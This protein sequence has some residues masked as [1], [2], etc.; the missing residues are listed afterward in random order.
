MPVSPPRTPRQHFRLVGEAS[1]FQGEQEIV[2]QAE[3]W[4]AGPS[5]MRMRL[6]IPQQNVHL[7]WL[8]HPEQA[9][10]QNNSSPAESYP[11]LDLWVDTLLRWHA[12]RFPWGWEKALASSVKPSQLAGDYQLETPLGLLLLSTNHEGLPTELALRETTVKLQDWQPATPSGA[13][14]PVQWDWTTP[15]GRRLE[16]YRNRSDQVLFLSSV[17]Q[18]EV[19]NSKIFVAKFLPDQTE[20]SGDNLEVLELP[21]QYIK[22]KEWQQQE[23]WAP[24]NWW[25]HEGQ[26]LYV[27]NIGVPTQAKAHQTSARKWLSWSTNQDTST[28]EALSYLQIALDSLQLKADGSLWSLEIPDSAH[29]RRAF[30]LPVTK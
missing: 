1:F 8:F 23:Q 19:G 20:S 4:L 10:V 27:F 30:L 14:V 16:K 18:P 29:K 11:S 3:L 22:E 2:L 25:L 9:W 17:F 7:F 26:R 24:G 6:G 28:K 5:R 12:L 15:Q 13:L 21:L